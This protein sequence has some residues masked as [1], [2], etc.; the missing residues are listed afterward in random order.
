V[1]RVRVS[2]RSPGLA[3]AIPGAELVSAAV[4]PTEPIRRKLRTTPSTGSAA[5]GRR[6]SGT[7]RNATLPVRPSPGCP[8]TETSERVRSGCRIATSC[9]TIDP[10]EAPT[11]CAPPGATWAMR[12]A[13][14]SAMSPRV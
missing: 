13:A 7:I 1:T 4:L 6:N 12:P 9:A 10:S 5:G 8:I 3:A 2:S 14:S 11:T